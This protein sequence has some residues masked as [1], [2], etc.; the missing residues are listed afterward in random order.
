MY[1]SPMFNGNQ[2]IVVLKYERFYTQNMGA[3]FKD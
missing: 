3:I 2:H 1:T